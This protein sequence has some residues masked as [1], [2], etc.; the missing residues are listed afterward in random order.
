[1]KVITIVVIEGKIATA[2]FKLHFMFT[3]KNDADSSK[4]LY[5]QTLGLYGSWLA[6]TRS[7]NPNTI[8]E[9]YLDKV[10]MQI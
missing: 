4:L 9:K 5:A 3:L 6:E 1:M 2:K 8:M 10:Y 7:E